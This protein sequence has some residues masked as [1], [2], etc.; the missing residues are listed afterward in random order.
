MNQS[1]SRRL[2]CLGFLLALLGLAGCG[3]DDSSSAGTLFLGDRQSG[4]Y[5]M[6]AADAQEYA[7]TLDFQAR[8]WRVEGNLLDLSGSFTG[9]TEE[10]QFLP[11]N[12][13]GLAGAST[14]R[15]RTAT[16]AIVGEFPLP[17]GSLPFIAVR[18]FA[19]TPAEAAGAFDMLGRTVSTLGAPANTTIQQGEL[20]AAGQLRT[21]EDSDIFALESC[22]A[23]SVVQ[24][25]VTVSGELFTADTPAG[26][27]SFRVALVGA[28]KLFLRAGQD[29]GTT[30]R[31]VIG[32]PATSSF[33]A[34]RFIGGTTEPAWATLVLNTGNFSSESLTRTGAVFAR[35][36]TADATGAIVGIRTLRNVSGGDFFATRAQEIGVM[37]AAPDSL[38]SPGFFFIGRRF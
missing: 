27:V 12:A 9:S 16:D 21:C 30:R 20:T 26:D 11:G 5:V 1:R 23:S 32:T 22:P 31:F 13:L 24:G 18:R 15:F 35:S 25:T 3:G 19:T 2:L 6:L 29:S 37:A 36:G 14:T 17:T 7:L 8:S 4:R 33:E 28:D 34:A 10:F 38:D